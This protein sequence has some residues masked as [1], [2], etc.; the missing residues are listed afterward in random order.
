MWQFV[1]AYFVRL[2]DSAPVKLAG[3]KRLPASGEQRRRER[4]CRK[5]GISKNRLK[6]LASNSSAKMDGIRRQNDLFDPHTRA[7]WE[8]SAD[9]MHNIC[10]FL[11]RFQWKRS[12]SFNTTDPAV[13]TFVFRLNCNICMI[14]VRIGSCDAL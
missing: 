5:N 1:F 11:Y 13:R 4:N 12:F 3:Q 2:S 6:R 10:A 8:F 14:D 9:L 7:I